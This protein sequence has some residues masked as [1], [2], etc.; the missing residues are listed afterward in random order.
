MPET[1]PGFICA[2]KEQRKNGQGRKMFLHVTESIGF[3]EM[4]EKPLKSLFKFSNLLVGLKI[5][6]TTP[7]T[8]EFINFLWYQTLLKSDINV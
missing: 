1:C 3:Q 8:R 4:M 6:H 5:Q 7:A 2:V